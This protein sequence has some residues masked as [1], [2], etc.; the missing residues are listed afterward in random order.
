MIAALMQWPGSLFP[1]FEPKTYPEPNVSFL[2]PK[3]SETYIL[4]GGG[5]NDGC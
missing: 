2:A 3:E 1:A 5:R 4:P